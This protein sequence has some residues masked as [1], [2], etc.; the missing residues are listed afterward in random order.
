MSLRT[1]ESVRTTAEVLPIWSSVSRQ[2]HDTGRWFTYK[3]YDRNVKKKGN[4]CVHDQD[5]DSEVVDVVHLHLRHLDDR[6]DDTIDD[7]AG[8]CEV[9][10]R[11]H[12]V[13]LELGRAQQFLDHDKAGCFAYDAA[14]LD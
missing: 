9:V 13:H 7:R 11:D 12:G 4:E 10:Q 2:G 1:P 14:S 6:R 8:W 5:T 3:E